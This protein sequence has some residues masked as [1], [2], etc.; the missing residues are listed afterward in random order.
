MEKIVKSYI[1]FVLSVCSIAAVIFLGILLHLQGILS[2]TW[3]FIILL[4]L[5]III[6]LYNDINIFNSIYEAYRDL[7]S[8]LQQKEITDG[9]K[10]I[11]FRQLLILRKHRFIEKRKV[12][13]KRNTEG[14]SLLSTGYMGLIFYHHEKI[15][16]YAI[17]ISVSDKYWVIINGAF[18]SS[19]FHHSIKNQDIKNVKQKF[20]VWAAEQ[21]IKLRPLDFSKPL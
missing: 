4:H 18:E 12:R 19:I 15:H 1:L 13:Q 11:T 8:V 10:K 2:L 9:L 6:Y 3:F 20:S 7:K 16:T 14:F 21:D 5:S 17:M